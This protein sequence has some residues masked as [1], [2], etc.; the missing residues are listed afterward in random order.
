MAKRIDS[1]S[2]FIAVSPSALFAAFSEPDVMEQWLPPKNMSA[3]M[4]HFDFREGGSYQMRL[5]YADPATTHGKTS[6]DA[7]VVN[8]RFVRLD[9]PNRIIQEVIF[10]SDD[11]VFSGA[12]RMTWSFEAVDGGTLVKIQAENVPRGISTED[13]EVGMNSTLE[14]LAQFLQGEAK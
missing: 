4:N 5:T 7:D 9:R 11:P 14:N 6:D 12:M 10:Q 13:H 8:V 3:T 1:A 2:K